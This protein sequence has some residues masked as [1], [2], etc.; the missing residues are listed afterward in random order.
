MAASEQAE[1]NQFEEGV[2][3]TARLLWVEAALDGSLEL[4]GRERD[5]VFETR[6]TIHVVEATVSGKREK[7]DSDAKKTAQTVQHIRGA[8]GKFAQG[9]FITRNEPTIEQKKAVDRYSHSVRCL[10]SDQFRSM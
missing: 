1:Q 7:A 10:S 3:Q 6:D 9:W 4:Q 5:G 2:R 8:G